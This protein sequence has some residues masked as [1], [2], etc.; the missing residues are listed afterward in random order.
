MYEVDRLV[1][2]LKPTQAFLDWL[3]QLP[4]QEDDLSLEDLRSDCTVLLLPPF[5]TPDEADDYLEDM[6]KDVIENECESWCEDETLWPKDM[7]Y[8]LLTKWFDIEHHSMV[9]D[10]TEEA[11]DDYEDDDDL[12]DEELADLDEAFDDEYEDDF[13]ED[14]PLEKKLH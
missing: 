11:D 2:V 10:T 12:D 1:T 14:E 6:A 3:K 13:D 8:D 9:F 4:D 7:D 5:E